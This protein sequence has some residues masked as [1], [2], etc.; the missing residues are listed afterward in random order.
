MA[1]KNDSEQSDQQPTRISIEEFD[2]KAA[3]IILYH[4]N[5][6]YV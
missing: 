2:K 5:N 3:S 6:S 1:E 4:K